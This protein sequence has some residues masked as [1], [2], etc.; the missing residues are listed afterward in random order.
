MKIFA[1][2]AACV[3]TCLLTGCTAFGANDPHTDSPGEPTQDRGPTLCH[4]GT[5]PPC[6]PR[7]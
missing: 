2:C 6:T 5:P 3:L 4:D 1:A 7:S